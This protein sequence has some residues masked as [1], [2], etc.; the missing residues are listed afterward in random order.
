MS[1]LSDEWSIAETPLTYSSL[2][3]HQ[4]RI[5]DPM[6]NDEEQFF[7]SEPRCQAVHK[8]ENVPPFPFKDYSLTKWNLSFS[9]DTCVRDFFFRVEEEGM[10]RNVNPTYVVRRFHELLSGS[11]LK[12]Y[13]A[14]RHP[15]LTYAELKSAFVK[16]FDVADYDFKVES[17]LCALV[18]PSPIGN[19]YLVRFLSFFLVFSFERFLAP[20]FRI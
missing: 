19:P 8:Q 13:R 12:Y 17:Q 6:T 16:T 5:L 11:A 15:G 7:D 14:I 2:N 10:A 20:F 1:H 9:G 18:R 3:A 4:P